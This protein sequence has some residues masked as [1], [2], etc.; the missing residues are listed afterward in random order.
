MEDVTALEGHLDTG[1][2]GH[3]VTWIQGHL[4]TGSL[5]YRVT[6]KRDGREFVDL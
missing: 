4:D 6:E 2:L 1:S 5:G 3:R